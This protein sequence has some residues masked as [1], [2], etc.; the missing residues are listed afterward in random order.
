MEASPSKLNII[1]VY[2]PTAE[3]N[4]VEVEEFYSQIAEM[5]KKLPKQDLIMIIGNFNAKIGK[6]RSGDF[7]EPYGLS[8]RNERGELLNLFAEKQGFAITNTFFKLLSRR[9][10]T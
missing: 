8:E 2:G 3:Q 5:V 1:Q 9:L 7:I 10:Y 4:I 6:R